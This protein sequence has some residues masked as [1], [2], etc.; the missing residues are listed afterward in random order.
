MYSRRLAVGWVVA[1][2][3]GLALLTVFFVVP[4]YQHLQRLQKEGRELSRM[5]SVRIIVASALTE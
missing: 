3:L 1:I 5:M 2:G 4:P